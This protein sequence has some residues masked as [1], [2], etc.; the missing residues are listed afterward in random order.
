MNGE[1]DSE[2]PAV[3]RL[4]LP[5]PERREPVGDKTILCDLCKEP[6]EVEV[7]FQRGDPFCHRCWVGRFGEG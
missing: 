2:E 1:K 4:D 7:W 6:I 5:E 3:F